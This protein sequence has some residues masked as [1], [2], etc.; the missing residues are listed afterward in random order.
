MAQNFV[1]YMA[2]K[3]GTFWVRHE[4]L[5]HLNMISLELPVTNRCGLAGVCVSIHV[6][7]EFHLNLIVFSDSADASVIHLEAVRTAVECFGSIIGWI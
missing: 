6:F 3:Q 7:T 2:Y 1:S 4:D 5:F